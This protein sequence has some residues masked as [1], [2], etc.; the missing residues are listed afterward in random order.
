LSS[1]V[2]RSI[3]N[4][5][6]KV[7]NLIAAMTGFVF[8]GC[9]SSVAVHKLESDD[10]AITGIP[11]SLL[12]P[13]VTVTPSH[14]D[15]IVDASTPPKDAPKAVKFDVALTYSE[16]DPNH[17][18]MINVSPELLSRIGLDLTFGSS[19]ELLGS[20]ET[21]TSEVPALVKTLGSF[22][23]L[24]TGQ[25][26]GALDASNKDPIAVMRTDA[27]RM[28]S[29]DSKNC[30]NQ[31]LTDFKNQTETYLGRADAFA[32]EYVRPETQDF[33]R[34]F[35]KLSTYQRTA[36]QN[37]FKVDCEN[38]Y[39]TAAPED[40]KAC[41]DLSVFIA[42]P[43]VAAL[44]KFKADNKYAYDNLGKDDAETELAQSRA[45]ALAILAD[46]PSLSDLDSNEFRWRALLTIDSEIAELAKCVA[47]LLVDSEEI[48]IASDD[49][50]AVIVGDGFPTGT[51]ER[52]LGLLRAKIDELRRNSATLL[53]LREEYDLMIKM[54]QTV[55]NL[56]NC[57]GRCNENNR[58]EFKGAPTTDLQ[59]A[60]KSIRTQIAEAKAKLKP[61]AAKKAD[62]PSY[63]KGPG[64]ILYVKNSVTMPAAI[65]DGTGAKKEIAPDYVLVIETKTGSSSLDTSEL[66]E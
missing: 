9:A 59:E 40:Q 3:H 27:S 38:D 17:R 43:S 29:I 20:T 16:P 11:F 30:P 31:V 15:L 7:K 25:S 19:G 5:R 14:S 65:C 32:A 66:C 1:L 18:Y 34:F 62:P 37:N 51:K 41:D 45:Q 54:E 23:G 8:A 35:S 60:I 47:I 42:K 50:C 2:L 52:D 24:V 36:L 63:S 39:D 26:L 61:A 12:A 49:A 33:T 48:E 58:R 55:S 6:P 10:E 46:A 56:L 53:D 13:S 21:V 44:A 28:C 57:L 4:A 64:E 22:A